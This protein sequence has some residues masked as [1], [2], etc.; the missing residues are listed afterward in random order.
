MTT[1]SEE[2]KAAYYIPKLKPKLSLSVEEATKP[3]NVHSS[4]PFLWYDRISCSFPW[5]SVFPCHQQ[6]GVFLLKLLMGNL[7]I[8]ILKATPKTYN[9]ANFDDSD[10]KRRRSIYLT[11]QVPRKRRG[12]KKEKAS[13]KSLESKVQKDYAF[14]FDWYCKKFIHNPFCRCRSSH[15]VWA[16]HYVAFDQMTLKWHFFVKIS[17]SLCHNIDITWCCYNLNRA[18]N[19]GS[20]FSTLL[21]VFA[22]LYAN[23]W[24]IGPG[25]M[26]RI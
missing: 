24:H 16:L 25:H 6:F 18:L 22:Q 1:K 2:K 15:Y 3:G 8:Y 23:T 13:L 10:W 26:C 17:F 20:F 7:V 4:E 14:N 19:T 21:S 5:K 9:L 11:R 12:K